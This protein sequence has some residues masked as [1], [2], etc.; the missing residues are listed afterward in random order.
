MQAKHWPDEQKPY[1]R[2]PMT[3]QESTSSEVEYLSGRSWV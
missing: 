2:Q 1:M 3:D